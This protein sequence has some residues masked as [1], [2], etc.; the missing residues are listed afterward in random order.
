M[1]RT[2]RWS[3]EAYDDVKLIS[4]YISRDSLNYSGIVV[5]KILIATERLNTFPFS[6]R[7]VPEISDK[8]IREVFVYN[9]RII[10]QIKTDIILIVAVIHGKR[11]LMVEQRLDNL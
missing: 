11:Q 3:P 4:E 2:V 9:Y 6:G 7:I 5:D 1:A 10:Y 8:N